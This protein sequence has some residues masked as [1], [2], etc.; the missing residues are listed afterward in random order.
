MSEPIVNEQK[1]IPAV[2][3][4]VARFHIA[5]HN[6]VLV[7]MCERG[8]EGRHVIAD[9][10][11]VHLSIILAKVLVGKV[12]K[13]KRHAVLVAEPLE[14]TCDVGG[15]AV[16]VDLHIRV[17]DAG[18][19]LESVWEYGATAR[20]DSPQPRKDHGFVEYTFWARIWVN[21]ATWWGAN[22]FE[23]IVLDLREK[24]YGVDCRYRPPH[25]ATNSIP[26]QCNYILVISGRMAFVY[27]AERP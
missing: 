19:R 20:A 12:R 16:G 13:Y 15:A 14:N 26:F 8:E 7:K 24:K 2:G 17:S 6:A 22:F 11:G 27:L 10:Y 5:M 1:P 4:E 18:K 25:N 9:G 21:S 3:Q 23:L